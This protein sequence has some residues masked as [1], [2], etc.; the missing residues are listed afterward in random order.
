MARAVVVLEGNRDWAVVDSS[1]SVWAGMPTAAEADRAAMEVAQELIEQHVEI[2][3]AILYSTG[4]VAIVCPDSMS[5]G[6]AKDEAYAALKAF[7]ND[8]RG[9]APAD[10]EEIHVVKDGRRWRLRAATI[11]PDQSPFI[12]G[13]KSAT[14][15]AEADKQAKV[16][17]QSMLTRGLFGRVIVHLSNGETG[18]MARTSKHAM[19][20]LGLP[21]QPR[22]TPEQAAAVQLEDWSTTRTDAGQLAKRLLAEQSRVGT[23]APGSFPGRGLFGPTRDDDWHANRRPS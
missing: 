8:L 3:V 21:G 12:R 2:F 17:A 18:L 22:P 5:E 23:I 16:L 15:P 19:R 9:Q 11:P 20:S 14:T 7:H 6:A 13:I 4:R 1:M 10:V